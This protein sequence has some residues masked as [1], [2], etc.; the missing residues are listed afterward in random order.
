M[1]FNNLST[2]LF[3]FN[4]LGRVMPWS[5]FSKGGHLKGAENP[6][7]SASHFLTYHLPKLLYIKIVVFNL[8]VIV[9][10]FV[11]FKLVD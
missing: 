11:K 9:R 2:I 10:N 5:H 4:T 7:L 8:I 1:S 3:L 6:I